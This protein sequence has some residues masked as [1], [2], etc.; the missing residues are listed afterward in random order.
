MGEHRPRRGPEGRHRRIIAAYTASRTANGAGRFFV[1]GAK[2]AFQKIYLQ[3][4]QTFYIRT[5]D[6]WFAK[7]HCMG[8]NIFICESAE[9]SSHIPPAAST[10]SPS[11]V[12][13]AFNTFCLLAAAAPVGLLPEICLILYV[14]FQL[15][16]SKRL[17]KI[18]YHILRIDINRHFSLIFRLFCTSVSPLGSYYAE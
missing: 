4:C 13:L 17:C 14:S 9:A 7:C 6:F 1:R 18:F 16:F 12:S 2:A 5:A 15:S 11:R 8:Y 10:S 3:S